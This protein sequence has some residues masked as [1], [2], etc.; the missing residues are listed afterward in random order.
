LFRNDE[1]END[2]L[3]IRG[4]FSGAPTALMLK[5]KRSDGYAGEQRNPCTSHPLS[6][7]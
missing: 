4:A 3:I 1:F 6:W 7:Q 5:R 2:V